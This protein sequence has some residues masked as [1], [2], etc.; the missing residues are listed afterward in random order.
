MRSETLFAT[1]ALI[2]I[3]GCSS[4]TSLAR[5]TEARRLAAL[6]DALS[7]RGFTATR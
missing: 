2:A 5:L 4:D 7:K 6:D 1:G 3:V